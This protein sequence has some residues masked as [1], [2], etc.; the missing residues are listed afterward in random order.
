MSGELRA[1]R[2]R[3]AGWLRVA[4]GLLLAATALVGPQ[5]RADPTA[6]SAPAAQ[7]PIPVAD[8]LTRAQSDHELGQRALRRAAAPNPDLQLAPALDDLVRAVGRLEQA[9]DIAELPHLPATRLRSLQRQWDFEA[10]RF[11]GWQSELRRASAAYVEDAST[12]AQRRGD[13][14]ATA[15]AL[16]AQGLPGSL[17]DRVAATTT[18]LGSAEQAL[19]GPLARLIALGQR[20]D[21]VD[22]R[23]QGGRDA[24]AEALADSNRRLLQVNAPPLWDLSPASGD[25]G[26]EF[27]AMRSGIGGEFRFA[28]A[29]RGGGGGAAW[30]LVPLALLLALGLERARENWR[31]SEAKSAHE[32]A[33]HVLARPLSA[34]LLFAMVLA[35]TAGRNAPV[36]VHGAALLLALA[37]ALRMLPLRALSVFRKWIFVAA[38]LFALNRLALLAQA[39]SNLYRLLEFGLSLAALL[40]TLWLLRLSRGGGRGARAVRAL[41]W[42]ALGLL[43]VAAAANVRGDALLAEMLTNGVF[44]ASA[45]ALLLGSGVHVGVACVQWLLGLRRVAGSGFVRAH[46]AE[47]ETLATRV[48]A[49]A[50]SAGW[51]AYTLQGFNVLQPAWDAVVALLTH[52]VGVGEISLSLGQVLIF[53]IS[54][55]LTHWSAQVVR[56]LLR[57]HLLDGMAL[58]HGVGNSIASLSYSGTLLLGLLMALSAAGFKVSQL[59]LVL[60]ALGVGIGLGLQNLVNNL[61][62]GLVLMIERPFQQGDVIEASGTLGRARSIGMRATIVR[63]FD[64]ADIVVPNAM[65][66]SESVTNWTPLD[67]GRRLELTVGAADDSDP[68]AVRALL[69]AAV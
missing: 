45:M 65:L 7:A 48:L 25:W 14:Q 36:L 15:S 33:D 13:W 60:S 58:P 62:S 64:G 8:L 47:L 42:C 3:A 61:V 66:V 10:H 41:A 28:E 51:L 6:A 34:W 57:D 43:A 46:A 22:A 27:A 12:L 52:Q 44:D 16:A 4:L 49:L 37:A 69:E 63:S 18:E 21:A 68:A 39:S 55:L 2:K 20:A 5:A 40:A 9:L 54:V 56:L 50:G 19:S 35:L 53:C 11:E 30:V 23:I 1:L 67:P 17:V 26:A 29:Y 59:L 38:G 32:A 31:A 24:I